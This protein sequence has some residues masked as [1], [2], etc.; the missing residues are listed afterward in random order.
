MKNQTFIPTDKLITSLYEE[1]INDTKIISIAALRR[2]HNFGSKSGRKIQLA[3]YNKYGTADVK[4]EVNRRL[5]KYRYSKVTGTYEPTKETLKK[6]S[7]SMKKTYASRPELREMAR[8]NAIKTHTGRIQSEEEKLK[9][10][11]SNRGQKRTKETRK[12]MS[13]ARTGKPLSEKHRLSLRVPKSVIPP[14]YVRSEITRKKLSEIAKKQWSD[15]IHKSIFRSKGQIEVENI[16][17][18]LGYEIESEFLI[19]GRP[20]DTFVKSKNLLIEFNG[21]FW[22]RDPRFFLKE[23]KQEGKSSLHTQKLEEI[24]NRD[25]EKIDLAKNN[26]YKIVTIWQYDWE[27]CEDKE[28]FIRNIL[29]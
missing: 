26:G 29:I 13:I 1:F 22:H 5:G 16:I 14:P 23:V 6:R 15:G 12:K 21:T 18:N 2:K 28:Q 9:R 24:W 11:N 25:K 10:A 19:A 17:K 20:Y 27:N 4:K 7:D 8:K 3:I